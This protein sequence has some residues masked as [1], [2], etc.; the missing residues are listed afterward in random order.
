MRLLLDIGNSRIK[1]A[2]A[3]ADELIDPGE[4]KHREEPLEKVLEQLAFLEREPEEIIAVNVA[5]SELGHAVADVMRSRFAKS[6]EFLHTT[7]SFGPVACGYEDCAQLG[8]DRW[9]AI[10]GAWSQYEANLCVV[11]A[12]TAVTVDLVTAAGKH[13]G[14]YIVPGLHLMNQALKRETGDI[15]RFAARTGLRDD[16]PDAP[17]ESTQAALQHGAI[18]AVTGLIDRSIQVLG[19]TGTDQISKVVVT[20][21]DAPGLLGMLGDKVHYHPQLVLEGV[22]V[23]SAKA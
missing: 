1:W 13:L 3:Q 8:V 11:D 4:L 16:E 22:G 2:W 15:E 12:G 7:A 14:G 9:A 18:L 23:M 6:V 20:G 5:G 21:G 19:A 17:G 10:I